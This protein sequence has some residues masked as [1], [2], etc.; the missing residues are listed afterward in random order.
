M[1][2]S[3]PTDPPQPPPPTVPTP[4]QPSARSS[5][6]SPRSLRQLSLFAAGASFLTLSTLITRRSLRRRRLAIYPTFYHPSNAPPKQQVSGALEA[7]EALNIATINVLSFGLMMVGGVLWAFDISSLAD[8]QRKVRGGLGV[9]G[10]GRG[11]TQV[12][13]EWEEWLAGVL[14][15]RRRKERERRREGGREGETDEEVEEREVER[16]NE[17]GKRR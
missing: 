6:T 5:L 15:R 10:S 7:L 11:T 2:N 3:A 4:H 12:E 1:S 14:E 8:V 17:R 16:W 13:E 9:D